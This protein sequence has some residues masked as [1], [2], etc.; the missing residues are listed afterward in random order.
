MSNYSYTKLNNKKIKDIIGYVS[1]ELGDNCFIM[2]YI[3]FE[4]DTIEYVEGEH[5]YPYICTKDKNV[6][7]TMENIIEK[8]KNDP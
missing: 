4:D 2:S 8:E 1:N 3:I 7:K 6:I 5:D